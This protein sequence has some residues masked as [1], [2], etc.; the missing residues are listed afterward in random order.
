MKSWRFSSDVNGSF[1]VKFTYSF[2]GT[3]TEQPTNPTVEVLPPL[4]V[5]VIARPVK[6]VVEY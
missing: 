6:L 3:E 4:D 2:A 5:N 1:V